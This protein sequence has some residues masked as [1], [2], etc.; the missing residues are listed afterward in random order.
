MSAGIRSR[1]YGGIVYVYADGD[2]SHEEHK[3]QIRKILLMVIRSQEVLL[4]GC[5]S[6]LF[7]Q[8]TVLLLQGWISLLKEPVPVVVETVIV[9]FLIEKTSLTF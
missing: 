1:A 4:L 7:F 6:S 3:L 8:P 9:D 2:H 5:F